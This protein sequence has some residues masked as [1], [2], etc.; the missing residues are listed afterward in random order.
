MENQDCNASNIDYDS[1]NGEPDVSPTPITDDE[2]QGIDW[3]RI[4][5]F[6]LP[7]QPVQRRAWIW[8]QG[9]DIEETKSGERYFLCKKCHTEKRHKNH[10]WK[11]SGG[12]ALPLK[13]LKEVHCLTEKGPVAEKRSF[14]D[15]F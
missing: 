3:N 2:Y 12:T 6:H 8:I 7:S 9:Y 1:Q 15:A 10:M 13:H 14:F 5:T 11:V 4:P